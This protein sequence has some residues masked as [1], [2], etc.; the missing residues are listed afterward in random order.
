MEL[1]EKKL[2]EYKKKIRL[3]TYDCILIIY[4]QLH[5]AKNQTFNRISKE[6]G[7]NN[8]TTVSVVKLLEKMGLLT[9]SNINP[10]KCKINLKSNSFHYES[11]IINKPGELDKSPGLPLI[12]TINS[13]EELDI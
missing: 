3:P 2:M 1:M 9:V 6:T 13:K 10:R 7:I 11:T 4:K 8:K 12:T 5:K